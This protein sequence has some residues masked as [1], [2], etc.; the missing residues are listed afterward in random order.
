VTMEEVPIPYFQ[1]V[2]A[3]ERGATGALPHAPAHHGPFSWLTFPE[4][5][6]V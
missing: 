1:S 6:D 3:I 5:I 4:G 2:I